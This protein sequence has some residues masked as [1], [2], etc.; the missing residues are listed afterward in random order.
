MTFF[1]LLKE[2]KCW[3]PNAV[4]VGA[5][6]TPYQRYC[7]NAKLD[8]GLIYNHTTGNPITSLDVANGTEL[9]C[10]DY[11]G[12]LKE[13]KRWFKSDIYPIPTGYTLTYIGIQEVTKDSDGNITGYQAFSNYSLGDTLICPDYNKDVDYYQIVRIQ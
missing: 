12:L 5:V 8:S 6:V 13:W 4:D 3:Q 2:S 11:G 9:E 10:R 7:I 1:Y